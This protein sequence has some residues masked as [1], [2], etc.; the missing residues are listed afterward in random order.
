MYNCSLL[1]HD[2]PAA[3]AVSQSAEYNDES[4]F[5]TLCWH[6]PLVQIEASLLITALNPC[7]FFYQNNNCKPVIIWQEA[8]EQYRQTA[9]SMLTGSPG[10]DVKK[11]LKDV[12]VA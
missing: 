8:L 6:I 7:N 9:A 11:G 1:H 12:S 3:D 10:K 5:Q 2:C 4:W